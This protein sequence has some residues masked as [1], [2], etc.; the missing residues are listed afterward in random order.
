MV[1]VKFCSVIPYRPPEEPH[2]KNDVVFDFKTAWENEM[3]R[4]CIAWS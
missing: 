1:G 4:L 3:K 2:L